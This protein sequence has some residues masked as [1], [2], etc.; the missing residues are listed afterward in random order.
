LQVTNLKYLS[1]KTKIPL[2]QLLRSR[3]DE[4]IFDVNVTVAEATTDA[5]LA[6][7]AKYAA[8]GHPGS[9]LQL[10]IA[11]DCLAVLP[12]QVLS[13]SAVVYTDLHDVS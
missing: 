10:T 13:T 12:P 1:H 3:P 5:G 7:I 2:I 4:L 6:D 8:G 11:R 9:V